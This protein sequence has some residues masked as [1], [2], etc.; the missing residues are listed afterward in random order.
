MIEQPYPYY[1]LEEKTQYI[2][3]SIGEKDVAKIVQFDHVV[4]DNW[5]LG[6]GDLDDEGFINDSIVTNNQDARKVIRTVAKIAIDF[7]AKD[8]S[9]TLEINPVDGKRQR[10]YNNIFQKYFAEMT[11]IFKITGTFEGVVETYSP[12]KNYSFFTITLKS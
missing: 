8:P 1:V 2:F 4:D 3:I 11:P 10:L 6:F 12:L 7:L 5:N 9:S